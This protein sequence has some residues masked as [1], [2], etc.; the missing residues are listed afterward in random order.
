[1]TETVWLTTSEPLQPVV[2]YRPAPGFDR[3]AGKAPLAQ[4]RFFNDQGAQS[5]SVFARLEELKTSMDDIAARHQ[6]TERRLAKVTHNFQGALHRLDT[7][8]IPL[9]TGA[10]VY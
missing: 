4:G 2:W 9:E 3:Q 5:K 6:I 1:M 7:L 10:P 8:F